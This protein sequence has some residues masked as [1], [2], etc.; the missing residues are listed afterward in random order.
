[1]DAFYFKQILTEIR[2]THVSIGEVDRFA[3]FEA[4]NEEV[5]PA[6]LSLGSHVPEY[7]P[8]YRF[9]RR[10]VYDCTIVGRK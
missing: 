1:M 3:T 5:A 9:N 2:W 6:L 8:K 4:D 7:R 10:I